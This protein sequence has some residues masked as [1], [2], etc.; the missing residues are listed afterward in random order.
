MTLNRRI[1]HVYQ[2]GVCKGH[3]VLIFELAI[4]CCLPH[5]SPLPEGEGAKN[6]VI[7]S[8]SGRGLG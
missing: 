4:N 2:E 6:V 5:P 1:E 7:P 3:G 8:P